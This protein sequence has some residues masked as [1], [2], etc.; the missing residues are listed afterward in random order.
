MLLAA[1]LSEVS[2]VG[3]LAID[4]A[5]DIAR[6]L[7]ISGTDLGGRLVPLLV[8]GEF[9]AELGTAHQR[10]RFA[11]S[12]TNSQQQRHQW[13]GL[14]ESE[15]ASYIT[16]KL[17]PMILSRV[18]RS[19][20]SSL[21]RNE[22]FEL[23]EERAEHLGRLGAFDEAIAVHEAALLIKPESVTG[24]IAA[25]HH[26]MLRLTEDRMRSYID[27]QCGTQLPAD[28]SSD[29]NLAAGEQIA[30][31][32]PER[33]PMFRAAVRHFEFLVA[34]RLI[35]PREAGWLVRPMVR[36]GDLWCHF[37]GKHW[38]E[39]RAI[40]EPTYRRL[41]SQ[42]RKLDPAIRSGTI[43]P[44]ILEIASARLHTDGT[45]PQPA[46]RQEMDWV[47]VVADCFAWKIP[48]LRCSRHGF[49]EIDKDYT[50]TARNIESLLTE[51]VTPGLPQPAMYRVL[52]NDHN[53]P[54]LTPDERRDF[55][56]RLMK[57]SPTVSLVARVGLLKMDVQEANTES[58]LKAA[59]DRTR[60][61]YA[62]LKEFGRPDG[63]AE[64]V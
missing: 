22:Q 33:V 20:G 11:V 57:H 37:E 19:T 18:E 15:I 60:K 45:D 36:H 62:D 41:F 49:T 32:F 63:A 55:W 28:R 54:G 61:L 53:V 26:G 14:S 52:L 1:T 35:N 58:K 31:R 50:W 16:K 12:F 6:E 39:A 2:G 10:F 42:F 46:W 56:Q 34:N 24:R 8:S 29:C 17:P 38:P 44:R 7:T 51:W 43:H 3:V 40:Q 4:E 25:F 13:T 30:D 47:E 9:E 5:R 23:L 21:S 64:V 59:V 27:W 48:R